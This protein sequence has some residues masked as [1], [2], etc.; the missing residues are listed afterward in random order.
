MTLF[1]LIEILRSARSFPK[2]LALRGDLLNALFR[3][4]V[5]AL[6][7]GFANRT[8]PIRHFLP[9]VLEHFSQSTLL[10]PPASPAHS[11][12]AQTHPTQGLSFRAL[13]LLDGSP[14]PTDLRSAIGRSLLDLPVEPNRSILTLWQDHAQELASALRLPR[15]PIRVIADYSTLAPSSSRTSKTVPVHLQRDPTPLRGAGGLLRDVTTRYDDADSI[16]VASAAQI[17]LQPL[18]HIAASLAAASDDFALAHSADGL[19]V[20]LMALRCR[21]LHPISPVGFIDL[22]E[23]ALPLIARHHDVRVL[24]SA[25]PLAL[26]I[27]TLSHYIRALHCYHRNK[28]EPSTSDPFAEDWRPTFSIA[29]PGASVAPSARLFDSVVL[30]GGKV[31][32]NS[33]VVRSVVCAGAQVAAGR[34]VTD[35]LITPGA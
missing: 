29:E 21:C 7:C 13:L 11:D 17:L 15:L 20:T 5:P 35:S 14:H 28:E 31:G 12:S 25:D 3:P 33:V 4:P 19:P 34:F 30:Q 1:D 32:P 27:R 2:R 23:Q 24:R 10:T 8:T 26:P 9:E 6:A 16:L 18:T 22:K